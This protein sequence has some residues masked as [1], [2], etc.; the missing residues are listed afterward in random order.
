MHRSIFSEW[1]E[2]RTCVKWKWR[3]LEIQHRPVHFAVVE[4]VMKVDNNTVS[5][6][7]QGGS[8][9]ERWRVAAVWW[10]RVLRMRRRSHICLKVWKVCSPCVAADFAASCYYIKQ[11]T[12]SW[13]FRLEFYIVVKLTLAG[14]CIWTYF[15]VWMCGSGFL[16]CFLFH[17]Q[18]IMASWPV[19]H[20]RPR[21]SSAAVFRGLG[22]VG[23]QSRSVVVT[24]ST[25]HLAVWTTSS[26]TSCTSGLSRRQ[27]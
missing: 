19:M 11:T 2:W 4:V 7:R 14:F 13:T 1:S 17:V 16:K 25:G 20:D 12:F 21:T 24:L 9:Q 22:H 3:A 8:G 23:V 26:C 5:Y 15:P 6:S 27:P 18:H 10:S